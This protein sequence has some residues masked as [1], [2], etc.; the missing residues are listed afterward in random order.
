MHKILFAGIALLLLTQAA[1]AQD[2]GKPSVW[3]LAFGHGFAIDVTQIGVM[4]ALE[5]YGLID[6]VDREGHRMFYEPPEHS[7][8]RFNAAEA[9]HQFDRLRDMVAKAMDDEPDILV[10]LSA[11]ATL[12]A[13]Q[14][15]QDMDDP[16]V[17]LFAN[18]YNPYEAGIADAP[19]IK[20]ANV[21]GSVSTT[22]YAEFVS[23][24]M[25]QNPQ[26]TSIGTIHNSS[27]ASGIY[28]AGQIADAAAALGVTVE[29]AA[30]NSLADLTLATEGLVSKGVE[31]ILL[32]LDATINA[33]MPI[34]A[35]V[36]G[37]NGIPVFS[38][39]FD[40]IHYGAMVGAGFFQFYDQGLQVGLMA[41]AYLRGELDIANTGISSL[42]GDTI[43][44]LNMTNA[45]TQDYIVSQAL[46]ERADVTAVFEGG[47]H[48]YDVRSM[49]MAMEQQR[50]L[51]G[52]PVPLEE[53]EEGDREFL[54]SLECTPERIAEQQAAL[55]AMEG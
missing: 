38:A 40:A 28:G 47:G 21:S 25:L 54:A 26:F 50:A 52:G 12:M 43:V 48:S 5:S 36:A 27:E 10:T 51:F 13:L 45:E 23:L 17:I 7:A 30:V 3:F 8:I 33:G 42:S 35:A 9:D 41:A 4:D 14:A 55:D 19:C 1:L 49:D 2:E 37:E 46:L 29:A 32:P 20:P 34:V 31:V 44:G 11:P 22:D 6:P 24:I 18:V 53:R 16:P 39:N 15:T